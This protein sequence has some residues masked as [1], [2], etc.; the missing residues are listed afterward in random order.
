[1][2]N[3]YVILDSGTTYFCIPPNVYAELLNTIP[4]TCTIEDLL[5]AC[6]FSGASDMSDD[7]LN[8]FF[9]DII[10][11]FG[12]IDYLISNNDYVYSAGD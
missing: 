5:A 6:A 4:L 10:L 9:P 11:R 7:E 3:N 2:R 8:L 1:M 12:G